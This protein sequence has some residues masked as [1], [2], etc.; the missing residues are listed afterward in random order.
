MRIAALLFLW[1][2]SLTPLPCPAQ[3]ECTI[4]VISGKAT[5]DGRPLLWKNRD[6]TRRNNEVV[7]FTD[8]KYPYIGVVN[9]QNRTQVWMGVNA[10]GFAIVNSDVSNLEGYMRHG[11]GFFIK[12]AL[13][14]CGSSADFENLL[15]QSNTTG[16]RVQSNF[17]VI[18]AAG[19]A[20]LF[21]TGNNTFVKFDANDP[22]TSPDGYIVRANFALT[23][24]E[25]KTSEGFR[26]E[27]AN[28]LAG[29]MVKENRASYSVLLRQIARDLVNGETNPYPLPFTGSIGDKPPGYIRTETSINR[30]DTVSC[31]VFQGVL[32]GELPGLT[33]FWIIMGEP[34]SGVALP[35]WVEAGA[36][37]E[38]FQGTTASSL[39]TLFQRIE[40][41][42]YPKSSLKEYLDT[43]VLTG[44]KRGGLLEQLFSL[45]DRVFRLT[46]DQLKKWREKR[47]SP[48]EILEFERKRADEVVTGLIKIDK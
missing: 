25:R 28:A 22:K 5:V 15:V 9:S 24:I 33:T 23:G 26:Y 6:T 41:K 38:T 18:D 29:Q 45:E 19:N 42:F 32:Q 11:D 46:G 10:A 7:Y 44:E 1:L 27:R 37:P 8:G 17:A 40:R 34:I 2:T 30:N 20:V 35:L 13:M 43:R 39:N 48:D 36:V 47:P 16:R 4:A 21:E 14:N 12:D 31:A 3:E